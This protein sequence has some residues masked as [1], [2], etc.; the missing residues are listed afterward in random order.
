MFERIFL[1][2]KTTQYISPYYGLTSNLYGYQINSVLM[3]FIMELTYIGRIKCIVI[4]D[5][6]AELW[7]PSYVWMPPRCLDTPSM[8]GCP[9]CL[10]SPRC[11]DAPSDA[12]MPHMFRYP[13][14]FG[15]L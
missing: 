4:Q 7:M 2:S 8:F 11:L 5:D 12:W 15:H 13:H 3:Y 10:D 1:W 14:M 6:I 9:I